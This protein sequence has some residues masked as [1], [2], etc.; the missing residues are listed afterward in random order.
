MAKDVNEQRSYQ[1]RGKVVQRSMQ[2]DV[3]GVDEE[4]RTLELAFS[5]DAEVERWPGF[6]E[7]LD[8]SSGAVRMERLLTG[9]PLLLIMIET[10]ISVRL[11]PLVSMQTA[12]AALLFVLVAESLLQRNLTMLGRY[13][14]PS[15]CW[16]H[17]N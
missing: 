10:S 14:Y 6:I 7:V 3:R 15:E 17:N 2:M 9:A 8:H 12:R 11:N 1:M 5:S 4:K 13:P 16:L